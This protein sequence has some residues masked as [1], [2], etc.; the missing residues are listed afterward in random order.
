M[1]IDYRVGECFLPHEI[2]CGR[3]FQGAISIDFDRTAVTGNR[4]LNRQWVA[5][6]VLVIQEYGNRINGFILDCIDLLAGDNRRVIHG[7]NRYL[8]L[9][10]SHTAKAV[11]DAVGDGI[12]PIKIYIGQ[13]INGAIII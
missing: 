1:A 3:V 5:I 8:E 2:R 10:C 4:R 9:P 12:D 11:T 6:G 7:L 13:I